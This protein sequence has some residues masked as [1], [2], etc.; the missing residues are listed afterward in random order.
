MPEIKEAPTLLPELSDLVSRVIKY[1]LEGVAVAL[2]EYYFSG[3][4]KIN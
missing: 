2:A 4:L 3:K 1:A